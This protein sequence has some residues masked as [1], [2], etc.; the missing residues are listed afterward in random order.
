MIDSKN[1]TANH[2]FEKIK[3]NYRRLAFIAY[4]RFLHVGRGALL[5]D[6]S[7]SNFRNIAKPKLFYLSFASLKDESEELKNLIR[8]YNP[9]KEIVVLAF[10][11]PKDS[12]VFSIG[13]DSG[14]MLPKEIYLTSSI[15]EF[16]PEIEGFKKMWCKGRNPLTNRKCD[17]ILHYTNGNGEFI[18]A[19]DLSCRINIKDSDYQKFSSL[20]D[21]TRRTQ[22]LGICPECHTNYYFYPSQK[23]KKKRA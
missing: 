12:E 16:F 10:H 2:G 6:L 14:L 9:E 3:S 20:K 18:P 1:L 7:L 21:V 23:S 22:F 11:T 17:V 15:D 13:A 4:S 8:I 5:V 19:D